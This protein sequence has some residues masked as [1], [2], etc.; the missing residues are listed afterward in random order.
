MGEK[1]RFKA[2]VQNKQK[3]EAEWY[4]DVYDGEGN[5]REDAFVPLKGELIIFAAD[6]NEENL[7]GNKYDRF[8]FGDEVT[9]VMDLPFAD[10]EVVKRLDSLA[11]VATTGLIDDLEVGKDTILIFDGGS[12]GTDIEISGSEED[13]QSLQ[14]NSNDDSQ[15][16]GLTDSEIL[17]ELENTDRGITANII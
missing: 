11:P 14:I 9:N 2:R 5:L 17:S 12:V 4:L 7:S 15:I 6:W 8:K 1:K 16:E 3:T 13:G 10:E